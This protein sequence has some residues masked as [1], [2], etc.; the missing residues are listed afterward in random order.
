MRSEQAFV[1]RDPPP[2]PPEIQLP[3]NI[4]V[5]RPF[6]WSYQRRSGKLHELLSKVCETSME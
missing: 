1:G 3:E 4:L 6:I 5:R 2:P